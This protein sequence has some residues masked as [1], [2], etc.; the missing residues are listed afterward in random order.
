MTEALQWF[1]NAGDK[2]L[3][4]AK[5]YL[6]ALR[7]LSMD[8]STTHEECLENYLASNRR[9]FV[10]KF[11]STLLEVDDPGADAPDHDS[12][13]LLE[14][15]I[16]AYLVTRTHVDSHDQ[17][18]NT[19]MSLAS[20][21]G[22]SSITRSLL[23]KGAS[24]TLPDTEGC[25]P[26]HWLFMYPQDDIVEMASEL[27]TER[28]GFVF[29]GS[30]ELK[31]K[32]L[33]P[34]AVNHEAPPRTAIRLDPQLPLSMYGTPLAFAVS[35]GCKTSV[36]SLLT[37]GADP[38]LGIS[39]SGREIQAGSPLAIA[40]SL[41]LAEILQLLLQQVLKR[42]YREGNLLRLLDGLQQVPP[43]AHV[44]RA[45]I[46]GCHMPSA[47]EETIY[48]LLDYHRFSSQYPQKWE[49][50]KPAVERMDPLLCS[51]IMK[52]LEKYRPELDLTHD[53]L[54]SLMYLV[55]LGACQSG[56][57][58]NVAIEMLEF[59]IRV[60]ANI[61]FFSR[62][63]RRMDR[64]P[65]FLVID[66]QDAELLDWMLQNTDVDLSIQDDE[67]M[68]ALHRLISTRMSST[69][70]IQKLID[71]QPNLPDIESWTGLTPIALLT[72]DRQVAEFKALLPHVPLRFRHRLLEAAIHA[73]A[74]KLVDANL[75]D[76]TRIGAAIHLNRALSLAAEVASGEVAEVLISFGAQ[77]NKT[78]GSGFST[79][80]KAAIH[81]NIDV[82]NLCIQLE[83]DVNQG[84]TVG[85]PLLLAI[86]TMVK[87]PEK[88]AGAHACADALLDADASPDCMNKYGCTPLS[89]ILNAPKS[90]GIRHGR[91]GLI[92]KLLRKGADPNVRQQESSAASD[93]S[94]SP[95]SSTEHP[96]FDILREPDWEL[97]E[98]LVKN[99]ISL[100][101]AS[102]D[103]NYLLHFCA[104]SG[105]STD[106]SGL[107]NS[108]PARL[109]A[110]LLERGADPFKKD[111]EGFTALERSI[112]NHNAPVTLRIVEHIMASAGITRGN[113]PTTFQEP[114]V[115]KSKR[116]FRNILRD[117]TD[118][119]DSSQP[120]IQS[121]PQEIPELQE[122][123]GLAVFYKSYM[124]IA[125]FIKAE[126]HGPLSYLTR[127]VAL[128][129]LAYALT[130]ELQFVL[131]KYMGGVNDDG[132]FEPPDDYLKAVWDSVREYFPWGHKPE[133]L[134]SFAAI[135]ALKS[136]E[137]S[138]VP[139]FPRVTKLRC[140]K[141]PDLNPEL[142][143]LDLKIDD[144]ILEDLIPWYHRLQYMNALNRATKALPATHMV[145]MGYYEAQA[146]H[147]M[148]E[149][150]V[151]EEAEQKRRE[152]I[153]L[154]SILGPIGP[155]DE[156]TYESG[157]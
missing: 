39:T 7:N 29:T 27:V 32:I 61:N 26:L 90:A 41:H 50:L 54:D 115:K 80:H 88:R 38:L 143:E 152:Y 36:E 16:K 127:R 114:S 34:L 73:D 103:G 132:N 53:E 71:K 142:H 140:G 4:L 100:D 75:Q 6:P 112:W 101:E 42:G 156:F 3:H 118:H 144:D 69:Y 76:I 1:E 72:S 92:E 14:E 30:E 63:P 150:I 48:V 83:H 94:D 129:F 111:K 134:V 153:A 104:H 133:L 13:Q 20:K 51:A 139:H 17:H 124:C 12:E 128:S 78:S 123:F 106:I 154:Q 74:P 21:L 82:L 99:R 58:L 97:A 122:G 86:T 55:M 151:D 91:F 137:P 9:A 93:A 46:H 146:D 19:S 109:T 11:S 22:T 110:L 65:L 85:T 149:A 87:D 2:G 113:L 68:T 59:A 77:A 28:T 96:L 125:A 117:K 31:E 24:S 37:L 116:K 10:A 147:D 43:A 148:K 84:S 98:L 145:M 131:R 45:L 155:E 79:M 40:F 66:R 52:A 138:N 8:M 62:P 15:R 120:K 157:F 64:I 35:M 108:R 60:G 70:E 67:G 121:H 44:H 25:A 107:D 119:K 57:T 105:N 141:Y 47:A 89:L 130:Y 23:D 126:A 18:G 49:L 56:R 102:K 95:E 5:L 81:G 135:S 136:E 33:V